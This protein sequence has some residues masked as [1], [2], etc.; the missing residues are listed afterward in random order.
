MRVCVV[1]AC[2]IEHWM[3]KK[4]KTLVKNKRKCNRETVKK[5]RRL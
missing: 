5:K 1:V 4:T 3:P 2:V